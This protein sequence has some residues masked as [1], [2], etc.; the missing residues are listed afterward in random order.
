MKKPNILYIMA[1]QFRSDCLGCMGNPVIQTPNLDRLAK[2]GMLFRNGFTP[3]PICVPAR[4]SMMTGNYPHVCTGEKENR[5]GIKA[6]QP[7]LTEVL[8]SVGY[9]A[10][11][12]GKLHFLPY[13]GPGQPRTVHGF[14]RVDLCESGR[15]LAEFDPKG[16]C[17][18]LNDF[19]DYL[20]QNEWGGYERGHGIGNNDVRPGASPL[21]QEL[22]VDA[23]VADCTIR[24][25]DRHLDEATEAPFFMFMSSPNP[26]APYDPPRPYDSMYDPR[27]IPLPFGKGEGDLESK[28]PFIEKEARTHAVDLLS[29]EARQVIRSHYYGLIT[30][31]DAQIGRVISHLEEEGILDDTLILFNADHGDLLGDFGGCFK[32]NHLTGSVNVPFIMAGPGVKQG[33]VSAALVGLQDILP[34]LAAVSG[35]SVGQVVQGKDLTPLLSGKQDRVRDVYYSQTLESP[36]Q[37]SM[38][39]DGVWKYIYSEANGTE[40]LYNCKDDPGEEQNLTKDPAFLKQNQRIRTLLMDTA[41]ELGDTALFD[42]DEFKKTPLDRRDFK[43]L[44]V[45]GMGWRWY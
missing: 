37:S 39:T 21:P 5:G 27:K 26:H 25:I 33:A 15:I 30:H 23:W 38:V 6:G 4:A 34:T 18:G 24:Q 28:N 29:P 1:D 22:H 43:T 32:S 17:S 13:R 10:Y 41:L 7:V 3:N 9:R 31:L 40:E 44:P 2:R 20:K 36:W 16:E 12:S 45:Q 19:H 42:G 11:A 35:A 8:K 14:E